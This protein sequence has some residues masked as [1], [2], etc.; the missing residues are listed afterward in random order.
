MAAKGKQDQARGEPQSL[1]EITA[2]KNMH[3]RMACTIPDQI[4]EETVLHCGQNELTM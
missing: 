1:Q 2:R 4:I 3:G